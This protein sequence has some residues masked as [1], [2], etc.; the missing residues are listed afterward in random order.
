MFGEIRFSKPIFRSGIRHEYFVIK[1][2][3]EFLKYYKDKIRPQDYSRGYVQ[4]VEIYDFIQNISENPEHRIFWARRT[5]DYQDSPKT[6]EIQEFIDKI[7]H[8]RN[9]LEERD[10][11]IKTYQMELQKYNEGDPALRMKQMV[12]EE[13]RVLITEILAA[14]N[15]K[16]SM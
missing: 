14:F 1:A 4:W 8:Y 11:M 16:K 2:N 7:K 5:Y 6:Q 15:I 12:R 3:D 13:N 9:L 10:K